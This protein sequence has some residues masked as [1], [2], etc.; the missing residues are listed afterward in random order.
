MND[1]LCTGKAE[2]EAEKALTAVNQ[3]L[4]EL[5]QAVSPTRI[6]SIQLIT[7]QRDL[8]VLGESAVAGGD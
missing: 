4:E 3:E 7:E 2:A 6:L 8:L 5:K 1:L